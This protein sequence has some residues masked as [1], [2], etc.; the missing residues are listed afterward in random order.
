MREENRIGYNRFMQER[1]ILPITKVEKVGVES[2]DVVFKII[3][4]D[5]EWLS[6]EKGLDHW[7]DW[8]TREIVEDKFRDWDVYL[9]YR[10]NQLVGTMS[11]SEKKVGYYL[12]ESIEMF[13]EPEAKALYISMLAV[14]PEFQGQ[15][16]ASDLLKLA[17]GIS[18]GKDIEY[19]R[20]DCREEYS[21]LV[22]FYIK[23]GYEKRGSFS[24]GENENY[25][26]MEKKI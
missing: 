25:L 22:D 18:K 5:S 23:R 3:K 6:K 2:V 26:M 24:E 10:N 19:V 16:V 20:F 8:Y 7:S 13:A 9:A 14:K 11:V 12:Q 21:E 15:G 4:E 1:E 17:E